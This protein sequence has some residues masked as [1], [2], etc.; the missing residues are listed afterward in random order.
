MLDRLLEL[1]VIVDNFCKEYSTHMS[2]IKT[3]NGI[4]GKKTRRRDCKISLSEILTILIV[5]QSSNFKNFKSFYFFMH[6]YCKKDFPN[7]CSYQ[8]FVEISPR[9]MHPLLFLLSSMY[10]SCD[11]TSLIDSTVI[12]VCHIKREL[13]HKTFKKSARKSKGTMGWFF[14]FKLHIIVNTRGELVNTYFS[15]GNVDDR[16]ALRKMCKSIFGDL[17]GDRGYIGA[18]L[19]K[20]LTQLGINLVTRPKKNMKNQ[21]LSPNEK[22]LL[23]SRNLIETV[24]GKLKISCNLEHTRHRSMNGFMLNILCALVAYCFTENKPKTKIRYPK[25]VKLNQD[26]TLLLAA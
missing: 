6:N 4:N 9:A 21:H 18:D 11:G 26:S 25:T 23:A 15:Y 10:A 3:I 8:R 1:Y 14:G 5:Y 7:L 17:V 22:A 12:K 24:I 20:D 2:S 16:I 13:N 19:K